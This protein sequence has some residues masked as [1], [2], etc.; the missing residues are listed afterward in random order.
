MVD[1]IIIQSL[2][3]YL[4]D[5]VYIIVSQLHVAFSNVAAYPAVWPIDIPDIDR[6]VSVS[7]IQ[8]KISQRFSFQYL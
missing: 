6:A 4:I 3:L 8:W 2:S 5:K 7:T 1:Y